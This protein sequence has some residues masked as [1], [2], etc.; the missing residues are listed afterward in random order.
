M[1]RPADSF[2]TQMARPAGSSGTQMARPAGSSGTQMA[3][4]AGSSGTQMAR[5]AGS[6]GTQMARLRGFEPPTSGSGGNCSEV[7]PCIFN[8]M[9][10]GLF[11]YGGDVRAQLGRS[12]Q[13]SVQPPRSLFLDSSI[14]GEAANGAGELKFLPNCPKTCNC[15]NSRDARQRKTFEIRRPKTR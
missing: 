1:A 4:P 2:G 8:R 11:G 3:R 15:P 14:S 9:R 7:G 12:V 6:F 5:P 13:P 10:G